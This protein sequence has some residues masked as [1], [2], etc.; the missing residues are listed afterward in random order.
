MLSR[1][2]KIFLLT[3]GGLIIAWA[4]GMF[5]FNLNSLWWA[6]V[7]MIMVIGAFVLFLLPAAGEAVRSVAGVNRDLKEQWPGMSIGHKL[8]IVG[9]VV[10]AFVFLYVLV[11]VDPLQLNVLE[12]IGL[13]N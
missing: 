3:V 6:V 10:A 2:Q 5:V 4:I 9:I 1:T 12:L 7:P 13:G 11:V 8:A